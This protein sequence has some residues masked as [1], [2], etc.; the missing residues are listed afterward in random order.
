M[1]HRKGSCDSLLCVRAFVARN[2]DHG[3]A[4]NC[5]FRCPISQRIS[6]PGCHHDIVHTVGAKGVCNGADSQSWAMAL[7]LVSKE[8]MVPCVASVVHVNSKQP[9]SADGV[10]IMLLRC[11]SCHYFCSCHQLRVMQDCDVQFSQAGELAVGMNALI[12]PS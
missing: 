5:T 9:G 2:R 8:A 10:V 7:L 12:I 11:Y 1:G 6:P 3:K 4:V